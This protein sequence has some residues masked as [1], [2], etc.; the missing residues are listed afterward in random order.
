M[1]SNTYIQIRSLSITAPSGTG[2]TTIAKKLV[3]EYHDDFINSISY[4]TR[5]PREDEVHGED[6]YF[7]TEEE[8]KKLI[9][10]NAFIEWTTYMGNFYGTPVYEL[11]RCKKLKK[12]G[13]IFILENEGVKQLKAKYPHAVSIFIIPTSIDSL[14]DRIKYRNEVDKR[15]ENAREEIKNAVHYDYVVENYILDDTISIINNII[16]TEN[17]RYCYMKEKIEKLIR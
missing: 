16:I 6:Y 7:V 4:T 15:L 2:K 13:I 17:Y 11:E 9:D 1:K 5:I 12:R 10:Q 3:E 14:V 8:F